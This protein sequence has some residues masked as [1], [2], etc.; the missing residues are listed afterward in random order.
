MLNMKPLLIFPLLFVALL[1]QPNGP[2]LT[3]VQ[4]LQIQVLSQRLEIAQLRAQAAQRD[5][6]A[7]RLE[8]TKLLQTLE[9][10]GY[11]FDIATLSYTKNPEVKK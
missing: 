1:A 9:V 10:E 5:F 2:T 3:E 7:A 11:T 8:I 4:K 6:D